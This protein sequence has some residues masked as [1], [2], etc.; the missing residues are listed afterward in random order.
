MRSIRGWL[1]S[2]LWQP[3]LQLLRQ[4]VTPR[5]LALSVAL[6]FALGIFP[7]IGSTT[8]LCFVFGYFLKLNPV[9]IQL[10][11]YFTYPLQLT[12]FLPFFHMGAFLFGVPPIPFSLDEIFVR[13]AEQ[14]FDVIGE[15]WSANVRAIVAWLLAAIP[16]I[17]LTAMTLETAF[18]RIAA[19][20]KK[21]VS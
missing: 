4:G 15:L 17:W 21:D 13:L 20:M 1:E 7:M 8:L 5:K 12:L 3:L 10:V 2:K 14:P 6:G 18:V 11:N 19:A 9:A 16:I